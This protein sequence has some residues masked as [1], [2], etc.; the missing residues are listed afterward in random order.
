MYFFVFFFDDLLGGLVLQNLHVPSGPKPIQKLTAI[1]KL[2][3]RNYDS[4][5]ISTDSE[6]IAIQK[7]TRF[8]NYDSETIAIQKLSRFRN[9]GDSETIAIQKLSRFRNYAS[10][11]TIQKLKR[12]R[13]DASETL[14]F[15]NYPDSETIAI[16]KLRFRNY[17]AIQK[18]PRFKN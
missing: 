7:L 8:R 9:Y 6:T 10:E 18:L 1:Q 11:T 2:R 3:F 4:E 15:R 5:T 14:R 13:N 16:Q 12:F 17:I